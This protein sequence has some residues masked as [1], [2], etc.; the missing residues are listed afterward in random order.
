MSSNESDQPFGTTS[1]EY[2]R[3]AYQSVAFSD[4]SEGC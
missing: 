2:I 3:L 1:D 4:F